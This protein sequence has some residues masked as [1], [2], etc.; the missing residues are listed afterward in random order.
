MAHFLLAIAIRTRVDITP[1]APVATRTRSNITPL[2]P[3]MN[4]SLLARLATAWG[5]ASVT[6]WSSLRLLVQYVSGLCP[7]MSRDSRGC[8]CLVLDGCLPQNLHYFYKLYPRNYDEHEHRGNA[9]VS[10]IES[11][12]LS[13]DEKSLCFEQSVRLELFNR[14]GLVHICCKT[15]WNDH[16]PPEPNDVEGIREDDEELASQL[17]LLMLAYRGSLLMFIR[18]QHE[19]EEYSTEFNCD[20][21]EL[22]GLGFRRP[23][24]WGSHNLDVHT[25]RLLAHWCHCWTMTDP[26]LTDIYSIT[27]RDVEAYRKVPA[28]IYDNHTLRGII[29]TMADIITRLKLRQMGFGDLD[30]LEV[31]QQHF[32]EQLAYARENINPVSGEA[33]SYWEKQFDEAAF[34]PVH[35]PEILDRL[36]ERP[37]RL[38]RNED[39]VWI[40]ER[41]IWSL[42]AKSY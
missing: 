42:N 5:T 28:Y 9:L 38:V 14:L 6:N 8:Y 40:W 34:V 31:I 39:E 10:W 1:L 24:S 35:R 11:C 41:E 12:F 27:A 37:R 29:R 13:Q 25:T 15:R 23:P 19:D 22:G 2:V 7:P 32:K 4:S 18:R 36:M 21:Y 30:Y 33:G 20:C 17:D 3:A 26:I 16:G